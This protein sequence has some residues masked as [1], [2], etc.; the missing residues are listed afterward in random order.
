MEKI[1][2]IEIRI[3]PNEKENGK[4]VFDLHVNMQTSDSSQ[5]KRN[6]VIWALEETLKI[7]KSTN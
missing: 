6:E 7:V 1:R 5:P 2:K 3:V 4:G